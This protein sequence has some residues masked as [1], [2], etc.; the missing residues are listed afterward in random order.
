MNKKIYIKYDVRIFDKFIDKFAQKY[1]EQRSSGKIPSAEELLQAAE[2]LGSGF[3]LTQIKSIILRNSVAV[4]ANR[5][6][7]KE[8]N[9]LTDIYRSDLGELLTSYYFEEKLGDTERYIIP[10]KNIS[11]RERYDMPGRGVDIIGYKINESGEKELLLAEAKVSHQKNN[12]PDVVDSKHDSIYYSLKK[13]H[14]NLDILQQRLTEYSKNLSGK[15]FTVIL[16]FIIS[17]ERNIPIDI[18]YGCGLVRDYTC[19]NDTKD[20]GKMK[21]NADEFAP[22]N[23]HFIIFSFTE[24]TIDKTIDLFYKRVQEL[25]K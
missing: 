15:D 13:Y 18:T 25:T 19:V 22:G 1:I 20:Y 21:S 16:C 24:E 11:T 12:P 23:I 17:I 9:I 2:S 4:D 3:D 10:A 7:G 5:D 8:T 6:E 14:D